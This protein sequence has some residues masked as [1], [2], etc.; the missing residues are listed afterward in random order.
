MEKNALEDKKSQLSKIIF[1][2]SKTQDALKSRGRI[3]KYFNLLENIYYSENPNDTFRHYYSDIF[4]WISQIDNDLSENAGDLEILS[5]NIGII[6]EEYEKC[7]LSRKRNV[8]KSI[9]KLYDHINLDIARINYIKTMQSSS[10]VEM[11]YIS[12]QLNLLNEQMKEEADKADDVSKKVNNAYSE[13]VSI[14]GIFSAIVLVFFGGT[15]IFANVIAAVNK[16]SLYKSM[17]ICIITGVMVA[18]IIF[19]F[20]WL[21][22]KLLGRSIASGL[23]S[24]EDYDNSVSLFR[25]RYPVI[26]YFNLFGI[27][28]LGIIYFVYFMNRYEAI[29]KI[30]SLFKSNSV[31]SKKEIVLLIIVIA[32]II[33][34]IFLILYLFAK[35][36]YIN[37]GWYI[38]VEYPR[39]IYTRSITET[40][41][42]VYRENWPDPEALLKE[43]RTFKEAEKYKK[44]KNRVEWIKTNI[45]NLPTRLFLRYRIIAFLDMCIIVTLIVTYVFL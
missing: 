6:K 4:G 27:V 18:D 38:H 29:G 33:N 30:I 1:D 37:I 14:L 17:S 3:V 34:C 31:L 32:A 15:S 9:D 13:F 42:G 12:Q 10:E 11:E 7:A 20:M 16:A 23:L 45:R 40:R 26:F 24:W 43:F 22:A 41:V 2:L 36:A 19:I 8:R 39:S 28:L 21:L 5:Q 35:I 25:R 44:R